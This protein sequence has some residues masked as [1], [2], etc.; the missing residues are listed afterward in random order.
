MSDNPTYLGLDIGGANLKAYDSTGRA[1]SVG[2]ALYR[3]PERLA[4]ELRLLAARMAAPQVVVATMTAEL[5]DCFT[6]R[7]QGVLHVLG[8]LESIYQPGVLRIWGVDGSFH[9]PSQIKNE[10]HL[11][12]ASNWKALGDCLA[13]TFFMEKSGLIIDIGSTTSDILAASNGKLLSNSRTD[14]DRLQ[15]GE[16]VYLGVSRTPLCSV[17]SDIRFRKKRTPV[18]REFFAT[19]ADA[20][21]TLGDLDEEP[22]DLSTANGRPG[23]RAEARH[24]LARM[25][26]LDYED[27]TEQDAAEMAAAVDA[28]LLKWLGKSVGSLRKTI[29]GELIDQVVVSGSGSFLAQRLAESVVGAEQVINLQS[30]WGEG[31]SSAACAVS[32]VK[33]A[34]GLLKP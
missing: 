7:R 4:D 28:Q 9:T 33:L 32:L 8:A 23:T 11:A 1:E 24:R 5:C 26:G 20:Y 12:A 16:L 3:E 19:T 22:D 25:I 18:M 6:T 29:A 34:Q 30:V 2:F 27:F 21:W 15:S 13:A 17:V 10:P 14:L 31:L